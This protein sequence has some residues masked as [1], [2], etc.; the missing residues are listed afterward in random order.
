M[1]KLV[2]LWSLVF[3][4][5][6]VV[7]SCGAETLRV[8]PG[9]KF[10]RIEDALRAA[11]PG[12]TIGVFPKKDG[13][14]YR[15]VALHV[16][17]PGITIKAVGKSRVRL[18]GKGYDYSGRGAVPRAIVQFGPAANGC[19][20]EGFELTGAHNASH[21]GA[22]VRIN[23]ANHV[24]IR[25]C[26]IHGNDMGIMSNG[27]GRPGTAEGQLI[28][29]CLIHSNGDRT[30]PGYNHNLYMGG[31]EVTMRGCEVHSSLTG[32]NFK[33]RAHRNLIV[34]CYIHDSANRELDLVDGKGDTDRPGSDTVLFGNVIVK[35]PKCSGNRA[36]IHFG[37]D[38]GKGHDGTLWLVHNTIVTPFIS[39]V[40]QLSTVQAKVEFVNN[41]VWDAASGQRN[42]VLVK[43]GQAN[44]VS[45][46]HNWVAS[47]FGP[48]IGG[49]DHL[50][51]G[52]RGAQPGFR[53]VDKR[54]FRLVPGA[55]VIDRGGPLPR[56]LAT[57]LAKRQAYRPP[58]QT[59]ERTFRGKPD[60]GAYEAEE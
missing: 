58:Q 15:K 22:G 36:V 50:I 17:T 49:L 12:D 6:S 60:P 55:A 54:D 19:V 31:S 1:K 21:N 57:V 38:G 51:V 20:L 2:L 10:G 34:G 41:I 46:S 48:K 47:G 37:Q 8:G 42:Q 4:G 5:L 13:T 45:G 25:Q 30:H 39:P 44:A 28:E 7:M 59:L 52:D 27:N 14:C 33:S 18:D 26:T 35:D 29:A 24:V 43:G 56:E 9:E 3:P 16:Q 40:V 53:D 11:K 32:H 23:Q